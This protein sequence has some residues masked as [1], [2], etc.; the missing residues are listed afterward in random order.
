MV[1]PGV[2]VDQLTV[3]IADDPAH[4][5]EQVRAEVGCEER[6]AVLGRKDDMGEE[7]GKGVSHRLSPLWGSHILTQLL[8]PRLTP[9]AIPYRPSGPE[10][11][12]TRTV[13]CR[14]SR[15]RLKSCPGAL[16][17]PVSHTRLKAA[18]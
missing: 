5:S 15:A 12:S 14:N 1:G 6:L 2:R 10:M 11:P 9:W 13:K 18:P 17:L 4:I 3:N 16:Q 7:V 8:V